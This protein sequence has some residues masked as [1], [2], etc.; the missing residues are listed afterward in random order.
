[1]TKFSLPGAYFDLVILKEVI[2]HVC[3]RLTDFWPTS[4]TRSAPGA[5]CI[6]P[7]PFPES[8]RWIFP[9]AIDGPETRE[10]LRVLGAVVLLCRMGLPV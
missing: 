6:Y 8:D 1:M 10:V 2:R 4:G 5:L 9:E 7:K 3:H